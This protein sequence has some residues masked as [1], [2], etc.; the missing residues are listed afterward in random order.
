MLLVWTYT[1]HDLSNVNVFLLRLHF[2][3][4]IQ[5]FKLSLNAV[6]RYNLNF[7]ST[8]LGKG[9]RSGWSRKAV[10]GIYQ[11]CQQV[12]RGLWTVP[13]VT[14]MRE[15]PESACLPTYVRQL[16]RVSRGDVD[17]GD[18]IWRWLNHCPITASNSG[19]C[20][21]IS[22]AKRYRRANYTVILAR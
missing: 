11:G 21:S 8:W 13:G 14:T 7:L 12:S 6:I 16:W 15:R 18:Q 5:N 1:R 22:R 10:D 3:L 19:L 4:L 17:T 20:Y 9:N 2:L